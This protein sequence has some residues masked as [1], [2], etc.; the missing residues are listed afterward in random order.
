MECMQSQL[1]GFKLGNKG[2]LTLLY[3]SL[4][5]HPVSMVLLEVKC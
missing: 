4:S 1:K 3:R 2:L 5:K